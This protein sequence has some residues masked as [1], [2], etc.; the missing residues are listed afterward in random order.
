[1]VRKISTS[2]LKS[3]LLSSPSLW[4]MFC[5]VSNVAK[6]KELEEAYE[7]RLHRPEEGVRSP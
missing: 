1:M 4:S 2:M 7:S 6:S 3:C 5:E